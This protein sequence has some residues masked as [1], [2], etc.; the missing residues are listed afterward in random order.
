MSP[1][2]Q[3]ERLQF[4]GFIFFAIVIAYTFMDATGHTLG[5]LLSGNV[6]AGPKVTVSTQQDSWN[7]LNS[8]THRRFG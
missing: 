7:Y 2:R 3:M 4:I 6:T 8:T 1:I 5:D